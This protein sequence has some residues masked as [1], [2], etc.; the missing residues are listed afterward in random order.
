MPIFTLI[1]TFTGLPAAFIF[2]KGMI[3]AIAM[4]IGAAIDLAIVVISEYKDNKK[5]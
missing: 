3:A 2:D 5:G 1:F 4:F